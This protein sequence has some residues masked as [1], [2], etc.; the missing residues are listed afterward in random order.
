MNATVNGAA[1]LTFRAMGTDV[2]LSGIGAPRVAEEIVRLEAMMTRFRPS[3]LTD[4]NA[5]GRL[6]RPPAELVAAL[7]WARDAARASGGLVT[8]LVLRAL[9][10]HGYRRS[11][12]DV[13]APATAATPR[14]SDTSGAACRSGTRIPDGQPQTVPGLD[15]L[16]VRDDEVILAPGTGVD[17]GGTAKSW[18]VERASASFVGPFVADAG[19]D[20]LLRLDRHAEVAIED[21]AEAWHLRL[22]PGTWGVATSSLAR[23]A[24]AG[25]HHLIDPR[26]GRPARG[27]WVQATAVAASLRA[28]EVASK[29]VLFDVP[30]PSELQIAGAWAVDA[31]GH[32]VDVMNGKEGRHHAGH[33]ALVA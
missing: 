4:L 23:R 11:W 7:T 5:T 20:V 24:W 30:I 26:T 9:E 10:H 19:G 18:I 25:A 27:P 32:I 3:P 14:P 29:L 21:A 33:L 28:A 22:P 31:A 16:V 15:A 2:C 6:S 17:L 1:P 13:E 8:P 12:P